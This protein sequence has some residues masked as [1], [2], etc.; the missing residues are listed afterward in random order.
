[1]GIGSSVSISYGSIERAQGC[2]ILAFRIEREQPFRLGSA[3]ET[4]VGGDQDEVVGRGSEMPC[5][6]EGGMQDK[7]VGGIDGVVLDVRKT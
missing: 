4:L 1:M 3:L 6:P 7:R 2:L 5:E